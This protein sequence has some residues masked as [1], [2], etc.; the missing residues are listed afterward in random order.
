MESGYRIR[1]TR[2]NGPSTATYPL[3]SFTQDY[4][5]ADDVGDLDANNGRFC[6][7]PEYPEGIYAYFVTEDSSQVPQYPY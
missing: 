6:V 1:T 2:T 3:G 5:Y 4:Y 7:T